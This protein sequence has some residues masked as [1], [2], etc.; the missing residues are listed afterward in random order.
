MDLVYA[1]SFSF[2]LNFAAADLSIEGKEYTTTTIP[3]KLQPVP[4]SY[5]GRCNV[6][7]SFEFFL[8]FQKNFD[9]CKTRIDF[10]IYSSVH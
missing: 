7:H 1:I 5:N 9:F 2:F 8:Y 4:S 3:S 6:A 10:S